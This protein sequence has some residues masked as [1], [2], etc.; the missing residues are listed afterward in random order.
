M[1]PTLMY[2]ANSIRPMRR[3]S[4]LDYL[5]EAATRR[6]YRRKT[7]VMIN[8][9][10]SLRSNGC[11]IAKGDGLGSGPV[12]RE[13]VWRINLTFDESKLEG[14]KITRWS[15]QKVNLYDL[16]VVYNATQYVL[17]FG[18]WSSFLSLRLRKKRKFLAPRIDWDWH[19][20]ERIGKWKLM[21]L[22][23]TRKRIV[24]ACA[25]LLNGFDFAFALL[26]L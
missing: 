13:C 8:K 24:F 9:I 3:K 1:A 16:I 6:F 26:N 7:I 4:I 17:A 5:L 25:R 20:Y 14:K 15:R 12:L 2:V 11:V 22:T 23:R 19:R 18:E 21:H 10:T